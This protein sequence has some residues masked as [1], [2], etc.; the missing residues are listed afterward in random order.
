MERACLPHLALHEMS[1]LSFDNY[2]DCC[3]Y[4]SQNVTHLE[5]ELFGHVMIERDPVNHLVLLLEVVLQFP[6]V[7]FP[8][9]SFLSRYGLGI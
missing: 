1:G 4:V 9:N 2:V 6:P 7:T 8:T 5:A 3:S